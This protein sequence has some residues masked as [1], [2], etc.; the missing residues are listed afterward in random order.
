MSSRIF[1]IDSSPA[2]RRMVEQLS[3]S[4]GYE[5]VGFQDGPAALEAAKRLSPELIIADYHL[6]NIT[7]SGF[8]KELGKLDN[9]SET[10][11][12]S[13][14]NPADRPDE[15]LL[16]TL[17]VK[18]FLK[19]PFQADHLWDA[20]KSLQSNGTQGNGKGTL[21]KRRT[22]P[23][24]SHSTDLDESEE[25]EGFY[26]PESLPE[27]EDE[28]VT[29]SHERMSSPS[30]DSII[31]S[32]EE[33][34]LVPEPVTSASPSNTTPTASNEPAINAV[35]DR[36][37]ASG[38]VE[39]TKG[40][41]DDR[42]TLLKEHSERQSAEPSSEMMTQEITVR[43]N[44][45]VRSE[46]TEQMSGSLFSDQIAHVVRDIVRSEL[47]NRIDKH[48]TD[49]ERMVREM[50]KDLCRPLVQ[51][52]TENLVRELA[53]ST[54]RRH[55]S[56]V[57]REHLDS[58]DPLIKATV[59]ESAGRHARQIAEEV[60]RGAAQESI[61]RAVQQIVPDIAEARVREEMK[62]LTSE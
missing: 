25:R 9:L 37:S 34:L 17:G 26:E 32:S 31:E 24:A 48:L 35:I 47:P 61:N 58:I 8:C 62:K 53:A 39:A 20:I 2:V 18:A 12:I 55:L 11:I 60:V 49:M 28:S 6:D 23:P 15:N 44:Q 56:D 46:V 40:S 13:L 52:T 14:I 29:A 4:E 3:T 19:K 41:V 10:L 21:H 33:P 38:A 57:V 1:V 59:D 50:V 51:S 5:V 16:R 42:S 27:T 36:T 30:V 54:I 45:I 43:L 7:F 22:W